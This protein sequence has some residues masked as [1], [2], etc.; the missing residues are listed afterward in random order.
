MRAGRRGGRQSERM[1]SAA[2]RIAADK[3][4]GEADGGKMKR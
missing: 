3:E 4:G 2:G 1:S